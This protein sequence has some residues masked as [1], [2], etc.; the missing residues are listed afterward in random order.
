MRDPD[1]RVV[2]E[3]TRELRGEPGPA[4]DW[5]AVEHG[6]FERLADAQLPAR[7][8]K[9]RALGLRTVAAGLALAAALVLLLRSQWQD[10]ALSTGEEQRGETA[11]QSPSA[12]ASPLDGRSLAPAA[13]LVA[14]K[15]EVAVA[16]PGQVTW[17]LKPPGSARVLSVGEVVTIEL[18]GGTLY[19]EVVPDRVPERFV[20]LAGNTRVAVHGTTFWVTR[21]G[22]HVAVRV[23]TGRVVVGPK[24]SARDRGL[25]LE[26]PASDRFDL[27]GGRLQDSANRR[28]PPRRPKAQSQPSAMPSGALTASSS[29]EAPLVPELPAKIPAAELH[30]GEEKLVSLIHHCFLKH[31]PVHGNVYVSAN[32]TVLARIAP[33]GGLEALEFEPPLAPAVEAC[34]RRVE[35]TVVFPPSRD[36]GSLSRVLELRR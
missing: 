34:T 23:E 15:Q 21:R 16:H 22:D 3:I 31:T 33:H 27:E 32:V 4:L 1:A 7:A 13:H 5:E 29:A 6:L 19:A 17:V 26:G 11:R 14:S 10:D 25:V 35:P 9:H 30:R 20:V 36:G 12:S 8:T 28:T 2:Q 24:G 18:E